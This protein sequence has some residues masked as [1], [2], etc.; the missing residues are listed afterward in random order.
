[1]NKILLALCAI[2]L[3]G[4]GLYLFSKPQTPSDDRTQFY[5]FKIKFNKS[6]G[7]KVELEFRFQ[8]FSNELAKIRKIN[9]DHTKRYTV[10]VNKFAD[11]TFEEFKN[12]YLMPARKNNKAHSP[13]PMNLQTG[14]VD[15]RTTTGA[16]GPVKNQGHCGSC[17]AFS[18]V[19][20]LEFAYF[21]KH[22][23]SEV[24]SEQELVD[25]AGGYY[26]NAG[27]NGGLM[28]WAYDYIID[29]KLDT[30]EDYPYKALD[31][32]CTPSTKPSRVQVSG[33][34]ALQP[35]QVENL[36]KVLN[37]QVV[38]V[39]IEVQDDFRYYESGVY[40]AGSD[41]GDYLNHG[42][43]AV[44]YNTQDQDGYFIVRNSW[45]GDWGKQGYVNMAIET[46]RGTCG[47]ADESDVYP[48]L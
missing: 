38:S 39:S 12:L 35:A 22:Q 25:C 16:V 17:W 36:V 3:A 41:C 13:I 2:T 8:I 23:T 10:A 31:Q 34:D 43:A 30:E 19:A 11:L 40:H 18:T 29:N 24:F 27:C 47:I 6:Y 9:A 26:G 48:N 37:K 45:G 21:L 15:W 14:N 32:K 5:N 1:M 44:G 33:Y 28:N 7:S 4:T 46:G 42:V 20:S